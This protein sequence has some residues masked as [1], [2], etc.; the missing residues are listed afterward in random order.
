MDAS[1]I[2]YG[3][4]VP[5]DYDGIAFVAKQATREL[6][7]TPPPVYRASIDADEMVIASYHGIVLGFIQFHRRRDNV[8]TIYKYAVDTNNRRLG[9]GAGMLD[10]LIRHM[11]S[12]R[13]EAIRLKVIEGTPAVDFYKAVGFNV[14]DSEPSTKT[15]LL[16]MKKE[17]GDD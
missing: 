13:A 16:V 1:E 6:G 4:A 5:S 14:I 3:L 10:F 17:L 11:T 9:I 12:R 8:V 15:T 7:Y 2:V